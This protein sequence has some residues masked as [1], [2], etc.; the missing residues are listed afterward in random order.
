MVFV[1]ETILL[2]YFTMA[3]WICW[4]LLGFWQRSK[5][6]FG[7]KYYVCICSPYSLQGMLVQ[8]CLSFFLKKNAFNSILNMPAQVRTLKKGCLWWVAPPCSTWVYL[9]R[10]ST[11]RTYTRARGFCCVLHLWSL[12]CSMLLHDVWD[13]G[14]IFHF[15]RIAEISQSSKSKPDDSQ[16]H[17][18]VARLKQWPVDMQQ[19][20]VDNHLHVYIYIIIGS[21]CN[22]HMCIYTYINMYMYIYI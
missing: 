1:F 22:I 6:Q 2:R 17:L 7:C 21:P 4:Q 20:S 14:F 3:E 18:H 5:E 13:H 12:Q 10:G 8:I 15:C 9:S 11:G 16:N 19:V